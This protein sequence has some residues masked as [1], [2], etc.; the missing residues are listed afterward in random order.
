M[1]LTLLLALSLA[2]ALQRPA[3][4]GEPDVPP[5]AAGAAGATKEDGSKMTAGAAAHEASLGDKKLKVGDT[6]GAMVHYDK[7]LA[8][9]PTSADIYTKRGTGYMV[10]GK[11]EKA[12]KD[13]DKALELS[14]GN[15]KALLKRARVHR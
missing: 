10:S 15:V 7:A 3:S 12:R 6:K 8:L 11:T 13:L 1:R 14:P 2:T 4:A 5:P 9:D